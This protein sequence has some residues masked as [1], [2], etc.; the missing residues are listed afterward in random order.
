MTPSPVV[1]LV[2][3]DAANVAAVRPGLEAQGFGVEHAD[4][5]EAARDR[6]RSGG[7]AA[8]VVF[9]TLPDEDGLELAAELRVS[10]P[11]VA[12]I[13][14]VAEP[15][16]RRDP[17][18]DG[19]DDVI[20]L[21]APPEELGWRLRLRLAELRRLGASRRR[22][23]FLRGVVR[24]CDLVSPYADVPA[25]AA[26][27]AP[28]LMGLPGV[29][30]LRVHLESD[31]MGEGPVVV[32]EAGRPPAEAGPGRV[33]VPLRGVEGT[34]ELAV[35]PA[36]E[37]DDDV[38]DA[39]GVLVGSALSGARQFGALKD[40]QLRLERGYVDRHRRLSRVSARLERLSDARDSFLALLS[41]DL[42]SPL[43]VV[44]GQVEL[45]EEGLVPHA[46]VPKSA[47]TLRRQAERMVQM[48]EDLLD[49][50]RREDAAR[51][52]PE[53]GD[54]V[55]IVAEMVEAARPLAQTRRVELTLT[56]PESAPIEADPAAV[57][58]VI[59]NLLENAIRDA[60]EGSA[61]GVSVAVADRTVAMSV[62]DA[63]PDFGAGGSTSGSGMAIGLRASTRIAA[64]AGGTLRSA[65][66]PGGGALVTLSLPLAAPQLA[67]AALEVYAP[68]GSAADSVY[69]LLGQ[70]WEAPRFDDIAGALD[71][72]RRQPPAAVVI[73]DAV[74]PESLAFL[75]RM[76]NDAQLA[77]IPVIAVADDVQ[78]FYDAGA[79]AVLR[80]PL[81][82]PL[83]LG[84]VRRALRLVGD[85]PPAGGSPPDVLTGLPSAATLTARLDAALDQARAA[86]LALPV[87]VVRIEDLKQINRQHGWLVGDQLLLWIAARLGE[88]VRTGELLA[89][90]DADSFAIASPGRSL[91]ELQAFA[92][93]TR[94]ALSR[95]RP[96]LGLAR[97]DVRVSA[98]A[99]DLTI[100][101]PGGESQLATERGR[102]GN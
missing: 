74:H 86:G 88:R 89:R 35:E 11:H 1:L 85:L 21:A 39:L 37:F 32:I 66:A 14:V 60:P 17:L 92:A 4:T 7:V 44:L 67:S 77:A 96:R 87:A 49:R 80:R 63:G 54:A 19:V 25:L 82:G 46:M 56:A 94:D 58:E 81:Q 33:D 90:V 22:E 18:A 95:A 57:R 71:R 45:L 29:V 10:Q 3:P 53:G 69:A 78:S 38:R 12:A 47:G 55:R 42:R 68:Q 97:V 20:T 83:L 75:R 40:R 24:L 100:L 59:A 26:A 91:E 41:H 27:I 61:V 6:I 8:I 73:D 16:S 52:I 79:L 5:G 9:E 72:M 64:E 48:V 101:A 31:T 50:Y 28:G 36:M 2:L 93:E 30:G 34:I 62:R 102:R 70:N 76:K 99:F 65:Q 23:R 15:T 98:H 84:H 43:A 13:L 51:P